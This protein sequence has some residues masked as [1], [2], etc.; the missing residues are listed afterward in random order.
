MFEFLNERRE[1]D[2]E[3]LTRVLKGQELPGR[4]HFAEI[5]WHDDLMKVVVEKY[6]HRKWV[7]QGEQP[8]EDYFRMYLEFL[9]RG[10]YDF[11]PVWPEWLNVPEPRQRLA[12]DTASRTGADRSWTEEAG[13]IITSFQDYE[14]IDWAGMTSNLKPLEMLLKLLPTGMKIVICDELFAKA[15]KWFFGF[16][17]LFIFS[18]EQP[19]LVA[20]VLDTWGRK[21]HDAYEHIIGYEEIGAIFHAD[22]IGF[23]TGLLLS[24]D[25]FRK[26]VFPWIGKYADLAHENGKMFWLHSCGNIAAVREDL[27][28]LG[29]DAFHSFEEAIC[30]VSQFTEQYGDR[31]ATL[32][33]IDM[34]RI[35]R[36][37]QQQLRQYVRGTLEACMPGRY[38]LGTGN[39]AT[40]YVPAENFLAMLEEGHRW[41][42][43]T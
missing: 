9:V 8:T 39:T 42:C 24:P 3:A 5:G 1:P 28:G 18:A 21:V 35:S 37:S 31:V 41:R 34:D 32:G 7:P 19:E 25:F 29:V 20:T 6:M 27:I 4:V 22:D 33:G 26:Q 30:P 12:K 11:V 43:A 36:L 15:F 16:E 2:F 14:Q 10:G 17:D 13:G 23:R 40:N 38:A